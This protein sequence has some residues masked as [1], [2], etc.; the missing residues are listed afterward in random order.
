MGLCFLVLFSRFQVFPYWRPKF[1][2]DRGLSGEVDC[3][4][5]RT[6]RVW[7]ATYGGEH[8]KS[9]KLL[10][11]SPWLTGVESLIRR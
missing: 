9:G 3:P 10:I 2:A 5:D 11:E 8:P 7:A 6:T 1:I 4:R